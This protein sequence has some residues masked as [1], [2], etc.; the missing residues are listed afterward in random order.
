MKSEIVSSTVVRITGSCRDTDLRS[1]LQQYSIGSLVWEMPIIAAPP[2]L[3]PEQLV[4]LAA[5]PPLSYDGQRVNV[6]DD[7]WQTLFEYQRV[8]VQRAVHQ[9]RGRCLLADDMGLGKT[10]QAIAVIK[11]YGVSALV[12]CPSFLCTNWRRVLEEWQ[13]EDVQVC[14]YGSVKDGPYGIVVID[15]AHYLKSRDSLRT[16][17]VLP[18]VLAAPY[19]LLLSGTPC[20]N[21]PEE[22]FTLMHALRPSLVPCFREFAERYCN[23]RRTRYCPCDTRGMDRPRELKWLLDRA[24]QIR[25]MKVEVLPQ[26]PD[27]LQGILYVDIEQGSRCELAHLQEKLEKARKN[28]SR[29]AQTLVMEMYRATAHAKA[30]SAAALVASKLQPGTLIFAHH[31]VVLDAMQQAV[32]THFRV[33]RIDGST[34]VAM[35]QRVVDGI[36]D[37][38]LDVAILSMAAAG[39]G[40][41]LTRAC[42][43]FF[44]EIPWCPAVLRQSEDRIHRIGQENVCTMYYVLAEGT[45]DTYVWRSIHRKELVAKR[46]GQG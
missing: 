31:H 1:R 18:L 22:L 8:G 16:K 10:M 5:R 15:E 13:V 39:V 43:A 11:H 40:L 9:Y 42:T 12:V 24:F 34:S 33:G 36:Q 32:P 19:A 7:L 41:T 46:I 35:R 25:R 44:L 29:L 23:P 45:L 2:D 27:K 30:Q 3:I 38:S 26:L 6:P 28:G 37:G 4:T 21:R 17:K 20:P 14:S